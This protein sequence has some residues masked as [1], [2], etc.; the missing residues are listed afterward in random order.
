MVITSLLGLSAVL[1]IVAE[2]FEGVQEIVEFPVPRQ[3]RFNFG[4]REA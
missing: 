1:E 3:E 4:S 2:I